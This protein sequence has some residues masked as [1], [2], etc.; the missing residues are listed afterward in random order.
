MKHEKAEKDGQVWSIEGI[1]LH[2]IY[3]PKGGIEGVMLD[4]DGVPVQFVFGH[5]PDGAAAFGKVEPGQ[6]VTLEGS[7]ARPWPEGENAHAVYGFKRL[8][9]IDGKAADDGGQP[10]HT[11]GK[12]VRMNYGRHGEA[13][14]VL[15][16][17]GDFIH[18][19][20]DR[21]ATLGIAPG[22][23]VEASGPGRPLAD[24][25]G[26]VIDAEALNGKL[27]DKKPD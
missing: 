1:V 15:L 16:D 25:S 23:Q 13:N 18:V 5:G 3:S 24:G 9:G 17:S 6:R 10:T 26:R 20:P 19:R 22:D 27:L 21:F 12:V 8:A 2:P 14:G 7:E 11:R 4:A